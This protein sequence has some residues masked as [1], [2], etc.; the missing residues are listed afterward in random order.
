MNKKNNF[1]IS[2]NQI[3]RKEALSKMGKY[4]SL[5]ALGTFLVLN[6]L[7]SQVV[8]IP[9]PPPESDEDIFY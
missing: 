9:P 6:P 4:A 2:Q 1:K 7:H 3:S 5:T 8:S